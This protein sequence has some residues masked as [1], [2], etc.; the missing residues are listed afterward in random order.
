MQKTLS[1]RS[2]IRPKPFLKW[3]GGKTQ[4]LDELERRLPAEI[5]SS[6][7]IEKYIEPFVGGGAVFFYL[8]S[9]YDMKEAYLLDINPTLVSAY[10]VIQ[11]QPIELIN[12][13]R[14]IEN[15]YYR[16]TDLQKRSYYYTIRDEFNR[17]ITGQ[18]SLS[19]RYGADLSVCKVAN[20]IFLNRTCYN[21]LFRQN[22]K[23][24]FNV[25]YGS[26][27]NPKICDE[28]NILQVS[29]SLKNVK[30]EKGDFERSKQYISEKSLVY[31]DPPYRPLPLK[32]TSQFTNYFKN[33]FNDND[34]LRLSRFFMEMDARGAYLMLSNS[35]PKN[36]DLSDNFF[37]KS[38]K[39]YNI[40]RVRANRLIN[41]NP[42]KRGHIFEL[43]I[44]NYLSKS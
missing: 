37:E 38:Y 10:S 11:K 4:L 22:S 25:P 41:C 17:Q 2:L 40:D 26:Y 43:V 29:Y 9:I 6:G 15:I 20:M 35:D 14:E 12:K 36:E 39:I 19:E 28:E 5:K 27:R 33:G 34:Q 44:T 21:G 42:I 7:T 16:L 30:I 1:G 31:L 13:L 24:E 23:G 3:A 18:V 8:K 32:T